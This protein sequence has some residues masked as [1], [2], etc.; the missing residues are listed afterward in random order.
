MV[1]TTPTGQIGY[2]VQHHLLGARRADPRDRARRYP[3]SWMVPVACSMA[4]VDDPTRGSERPGAQQRFIDG[5]CRQGLTIRKASSLVLCCVHQEH[6]PN[7]LNCDGAECL[8]AQQGDD[9]LCA[10]IALE[11]GWWTSPADIGSQW[12]RREQLWDYGQEL[13]RV[14][15]EE[16]DITPLRAWP[17][18]FWKMGFPSKSDSSSLGWFR[19]V[20]PWRSSHTPRS[21]R[22]RLQ[23]RNRGINST[24]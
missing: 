18:S 3:K 21:S 20:H 13:L 22:Q 6:V 2:Q 19:A 9:T 16:G 11:A 12:D 23:Q 5:C 8:R 15:D 7:V 17:I 4:R 10:R 14:D 1:M 24:A